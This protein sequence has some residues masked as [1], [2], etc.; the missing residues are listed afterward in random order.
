[1]LFFFILFA[2]SFPNL[3]IIL[4]VQT[5]SNQKQWLWISDVNISMFVHTRVLLCIIIY[6][7]ITD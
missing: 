4:Y 6:Y 3:N 7:L 5:V 1:M 2:Y